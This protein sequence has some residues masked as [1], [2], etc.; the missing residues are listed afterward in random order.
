MAKLR[1]TAH[2]PAAGSPPSPF[3][4]RTC[5]REGGTRFKN[6]RSPHRMLRPVLLLWAGTRKPGTAQTEAL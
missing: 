3:F 6:N 1:K 2:L 5:Q 4:E